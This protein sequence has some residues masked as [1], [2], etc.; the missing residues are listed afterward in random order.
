MT[1]KLVQLYIPGTASIY[2]IFSLIFE[3]PYT[4]QIIGILAIFSTMLGLILRR[5]SNHHDGKIVVETSESGGK[6]FSLELEGD[7]V[8]LEEKDSVSFKIVSGQN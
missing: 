1:K 4:V 2:F 7:P 3:L 5:V 6:V 8:E